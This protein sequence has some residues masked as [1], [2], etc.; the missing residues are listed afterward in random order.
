MKKV[1]EARSCQGFDEIGGVY[2]HVVGT[3]AL[4]PGAASAT[5]TSAVT[6]MVGILTDFEVLVSIVFSCGMRERPSL[7]NA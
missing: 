4:L 7:S 1:R 3:V 6:L 2:L 5:T